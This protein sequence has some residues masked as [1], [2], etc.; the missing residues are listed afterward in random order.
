MR[1]LPGCQE[2][3]T[4]LCL[5]FAPA[6]MSLVMVL[7]LLLPNKCCF[8]CIWAWD[9]SRGLCHFL[10]AWMMIFAPKQLFMWHHLSG[11]L[12][13][14]VNRLLF[15]TDCRLFM[16]F[17]LIICIPGPSAKKGVYGVLISQGEDRGL[18]RTPLFCC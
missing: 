3:G 4:W 8:L 2:A 18:G 6:L 15:I 13:L 11:T 5:L 1:P 12:I 7:L 10:R 14:M 17:F 16:R 9:C